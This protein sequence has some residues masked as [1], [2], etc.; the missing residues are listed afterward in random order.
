MPSS[1]SKF[2]DDDELAKVRELYAASLAAVEAEETGGGAVASPR[3]GAVT[4]PPPEPGPGAE[5]SR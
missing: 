3:P 1:F 2:L 5:G 4:P